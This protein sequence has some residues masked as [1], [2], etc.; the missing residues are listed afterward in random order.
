MK[1]Y[2]YLFE[3]KDNGYG[4]NCDRTYFSCHTKLTQDKVNELIRS[5]NC[6]A[7]RIGS[8]FEDFKNG[9]K[10]EGIFIQ[11]LKNQHPVD[12]VFEN[13]QGNY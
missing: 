9:A 2:I 12:G 8:S 3:A 1:S 10:K 7:G 5:V 4:I 11:E 6:A 13:I